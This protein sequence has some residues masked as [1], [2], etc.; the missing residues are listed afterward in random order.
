[1]NRASFFTGVLLLA[2]GVWFLGGCPTLKEVDIPCESSL[3][4]P[5]DFGCAS[6]KICARVPESTL[7][8]EADK[9]SVNA[10]ELVTLGA[11]LDGQD[12][13]DVTW[14]V[15]GKGTGTISDLGV[16]TAP[17][18]ITIPIKVKIW[19]ALSSD[20]SFKASTTVTVIPVDDTVA[21]VMSYFRGG[22]S[23]TEVAKDSLHLAYSKDRKQWIMLSPSNPAYQLSEMESN[24]LRDPFVFR[25]LDGTFVLLATDWT[26]SYGDSDYYPSS[27]IIVV[28]S[29]DLIT[30]E[31]P[32]LLRV[33]SAQDNSG[34]PMHAWAPEAFYDPYLDQY[35][36]LW[37]G[38]D[39][40][41]VNRIYVSYTTDFRQPVNETPVVFFDPGYSVVDPTL[42]QTVN[43]NYLLFKDD[44][45]G[46][47]DAGLLIGQDVQIAATDTS[48]LIP[49]TFKSWSSQYIPRGSSQ[50]T[51]FGTEG[52]Y[53]VMMPYEA[54]DTTFWYMCASASGGG[55]GC[56]GT[57]NLDVAP[58]S[59]VRMD[60]QGVPTD[61][62]HASTIRVTQTE[63]DALIEHYGTA[64]TG[65]D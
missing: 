48:E 49:G 63:L 56:W 61:A 58:S 59:W 64:S 37:A 62:R 25:K 18:G 24:R 29:P 17:L 12:I 34:M 14:S 33:T 16:Y 27:N 43:R 47:L 28:D 52:P 60:M 44:R 35:G 38:N 7:T 4:C 50:S 36:I 31:N 5:T 57:E 42:L 20:S 2:G 13:T 1:M 21:W 41:N 65:Q 51:V 55:L 26:L 40:N 22:T 45:L 8:V 19:A 53:M 10:D 32:R 3:D 11:K 15:E 6:N 39:Q 23:S 46:V 30:F 9:P 54:W